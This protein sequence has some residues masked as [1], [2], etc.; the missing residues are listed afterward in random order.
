LTAPLFHAGALRQKVDIQS[1]LQEQ[2]LL[3][4]ESTVLTALQETENAL[5]AY[6]EELTRR[7]ALRQSV[8]A[9]KAAARLA[10]SKFE[11]GLTDFT[12]VLE[13]QRSLFSFEDQLVQSEG[14]VTSNL[15]R[16]YKALG[17]GWESVAS[18]TKTTG[19]TGGDM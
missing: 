15:V 9:A 12:A 4:Y 8:Q 7:E 13:A 3:Q 14:A 18:D 6:G 5:V 2:A 11:A 10:Q 17:G 16:L 19:Q 1:A